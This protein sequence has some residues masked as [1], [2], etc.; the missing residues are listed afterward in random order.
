MLQSKTLVTALLTAMLVATQLSAQE[1]TATT[2]AQGRFKL[3]EE[4]AGFRL[5]LDRY[6]SAAT[7]ETST[8]VAKL[9]ELE[10][11]LDALK[12]ELR[13]KTEQPKQIYLDLK[14]I[15]VK[16]DRVV[17][18][19]LYR[20]QPEVMT[21]QRFAQLSKE[22]DVLQAPRVIALDRQKASIFVG[23]EQEIPFLQRAADGRYDMK[24]EKVTDGIEME[25]TGQ[26]KDAMIHFD[27]HASVTRIVGKTPCEPG[28]ATVGAPLLSKRA[29]ESEFLFKPGTRIAI[30][31]AHHGDDDD[32]CVFITLEARVL[33]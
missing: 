16:R 5:A 17:M 11:A 33:D 19:P 9:R 14:F 4:I 31:L 3:S 7:D 32:T 2:D 23:D 28:A 25:V 26:I 24:V 18:T 22:A 21:D 8:I 20:G 6:K 12:A 13:D 30:P 10:T 29:V 27:L 15:E 1:R